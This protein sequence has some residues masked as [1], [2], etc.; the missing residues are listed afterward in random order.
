MKF[1]AGF[2]AAILTAPVLL[3][4]V[5]YSGAYNVAAT[6]AHF[7]LTQQAL[8][9][10]R[11]RSI[12]AH[13]NDIAPA[14]FDSKQAHEGFHEYAE[15]CVTCHGAPGRQQTE[16]AKGLSPAPPDLKQTVSRWKRAELFWIVKNGIK[17]TGMPAFGPSHDDA[18]IWSIV[19][20]VEGLPDLSAEQYQKMGT[21]HA[22]ESHHHH[23]H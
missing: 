21:G 6:D 16:I 13:A 18:T 14:R 12:R 7:P 22:E 1:I 9:I 5:M 3:A 20:F 2:A 23:E 4:A 10:L 15:M 19:A 17:S 11:I 8:D